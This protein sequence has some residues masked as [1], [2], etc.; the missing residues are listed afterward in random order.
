MRF[1]RFIGALVLI[2]VA[3][4]G[5]ITYAAL[6]LQEVVLLRTRDPEGH[7]KIRRLLREKYGLADW[8]V[9]LFQDTS[10]SVAIHLRPT[11]SD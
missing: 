10:G 11:G 7:A 9:G 3:G 2:T 5:V 8:W 6:E 4:V 1:A